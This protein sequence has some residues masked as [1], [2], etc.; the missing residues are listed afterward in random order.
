MRGSARVVVSSSLGIIY[1]L[2]NFYLFIFVKSDF[3]QL[4]DPPQMDL[5]WG[6]VD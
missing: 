5:E 3:S 1:F 2:A 6:F 4:P